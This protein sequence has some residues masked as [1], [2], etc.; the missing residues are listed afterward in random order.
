MG[1]VLCVGE[2]MVQV[3]PLRGHGI[4]RDTE[5]HLVPGGAESNVASL[6]AQLGHSATWL[7]AVGDDPFGRLIE[8][9]LAADGVDVSKVKRDKNHKT[10]VYFKDLSGGTTTVH[11]YRDSSAASHLDPSIL[12]TVA[13]KSWDLVHMSGVTPA[14]SDSCNQLVDSVLRKRVFGDVTVSFDINYRRSLWPVE[15]A[16]VS[17]EAYA[18]QADIVFVGLDEARELWGLETAQ[19]VR[20]L[21][22]KP[23]FVIIKDS[24]VDATE[25]DG[26]TTTKEPA[27]RVDVVEKV[28]AGDAFA[29]GWL[30]GFLSSRTRSERLKLGHLMAAEVLKTT[31]DSVA[32]P[33]ATS[34]DSLLSQ[35]RIALK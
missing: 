21:L 23:D 17:L 35:H 27:V 14:L 7:G 11:Y 29:A 28:G 1:S 25:F 34:V 20:D 8:S 9:S 22:C 33:F 4:T 13:S 10:G 31:T 19:A 24:D 30:S 12:E 2:T 6:V 18:N 16:S 5:F 15:T 3:T 26:E 32:V